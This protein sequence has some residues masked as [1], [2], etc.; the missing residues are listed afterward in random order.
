MFGDLVYWYS[1]GI[2]VMC[3]ILGEFIKGD[4]RN[5]GLNSWA[6]SRYRSP[7]KSYFVDNAKYQGSQQSTSLL[8]IA[9]LFPFR[10][11][12]HVCLL[13]D[14]MRRRGNWGFSVGRR[15]NC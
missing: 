2:S 10:F 15:K 4:R 5:W 8:L 14:F 3:I 7:W 9:I 1:G 11:S 6:A 12:S 13:L